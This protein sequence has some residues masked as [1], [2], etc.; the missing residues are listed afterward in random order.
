MSAQISSHKISRGVS[1][2]KVLA[3]SGALVVGFSLFARTGSDTA[4]AQAAAAPPV[5]PSLGKAPQV[6]SWIRISAAGEVTVLTGKVEIGQGVR[7]SL[8]QIVAD[9]LDVALARV[10][11]V[12]ADT[13]RTPDETTTSRSHSMIESGGA[14]R[15]AAAEAR[16]FLL[17]KA[18]ERLNVQASALSVQ[19]GTISA[20]LPNAG[21]GRVGVAQISYWA[22][23]G[24]NKFDRAVSGKAA[25]KP[26]SAYK[27]VGKSIPRVD[28][29][30]KVTGAPS[31]VQ[32]L[33]LPGMLH[34]RVLRP[35]IDRPV[36]L[37]SIDVG[38]AAAMPGVVKVVQNGSFV[39][40]IAERE[41]EAIRAL[42]ALKQSASWDLPQLPPQAQLKAQLRSLPAKERVLRNDAG[43][44]DALAKAAHR[45][46]ASYFVPF[47]SHGSIGPSCAVAQLSDG[48]LT[49]WTH[50]QGV[51]QLRTD[52][53]QVLDKP[54]SQIRLI[55]MEGAACYGQNGADDVPL[56]AAVLATAVP[57]RPVRVQWM[58]QDEFAWAPKGP[59]MIVDIKAG[60]D[61]QG[62]IVAWDHE[63][64]TGPHVSR[65]G[66]KGKSVA[67]G[68]WY[69]ERPAAPFYLQG[70]AA[71]VVARGLAAAEAFYGFPNK[72]VVEHV[73]E[74]F[75]PLRSGELRGVAALPHAFALESMVDELAAKAGSDPIE[76]RLRFIKDARMRAVIEAAAKQ[77]GWTP[78]RAPSGKGRGVST[79]YYDRPMARGACIAEVEVDRPSGRIKVNRVVAAFDVGQIVNP[80]GVRNQM[81]GGIIQ[82]LS[83]TLVEEMT[84]ADGK[85]S[86]VDW[87]SYPL[88]GFNDLPE[89]DIVLLDRPD[90]PPGGAGET[91]TPL[92]PGAIANAV[93]DAVGT[94]LRDLPFTPARVRAALA[95]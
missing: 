82:A 46:E 23:I 42:E 36:K 52:L 17:A 69:L 7:T 94:R 9:E 92:I 67:I 63:Y 49:V 78:G 29:P 61:A 93:Y 10:V 60:A 33:R 38:R 59:A 16:A 43:V 66:S 37:K 5:S 45:I 58:R 62:N 31:Y 28:I 48:A 39:G 87:S 81:E 53:A 76:F 75:S 77:A 11:V 30:G 72:R 2:R 74:L 71:D 25:T 4:C 34:A 35:P 22:I 13:A 50:S 89:I 8:A 83:R 64:W 44:A 3:G 6:D 47:Q 70:P 32:D 73:T 27:Y 91:Q 21:Q 55:H 80:D 88:L 40:V 18:A 41:E 86:S 14:L 20:P 1:R 51:F 54:E 84:Y 90:E 26:P 95:G 15:A 85:V 56:D 65:Y 57:G 12:T 79:F 19:D 68:A 24:D